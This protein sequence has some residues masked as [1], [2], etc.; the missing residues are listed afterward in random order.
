MV[1][2][3]CASCVVFRLSICFFKCSPEFPLR[4]STMCCPLMFL[5]CTSYF[6]C[7]LASPWRCLP[8]LSSCLPLVISSLS[9]HLLAPQCSSG[10]QAL[11]VLAFMFFHGVFPPKELPCETFFRYPLIVNSPSS[12]ELSTPPVLCSSCWLLVFFLECWCSCVSLVFFCCLALCG[13]LLLGFPCASRLCF[14]LHVPL[15]FPPYV[16]SLFLP[17]CF[18]FVF[19]SVCFLPVRS[20]I[21]FSSCVCNS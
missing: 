5:L 16:L 13:C 10:A 9:L 7:P 12:S 11:L 2:P 1:F 8:V 6:C 3:S 18:P 14:C 19:P 21:C 20:P 17:S 15:A 4:V